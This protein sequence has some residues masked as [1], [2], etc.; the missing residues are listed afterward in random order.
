MSTV[1]DQPGGQ[2][3]YV[4]GILASLG[5]LSLG[6]AIGWSSPAQYYIM[7]KD[8]SGFPVTLDEFG[9]ICAA[10]WL[11]FG[12]V[13]IPSGILSE[14]WGRKTVM[15]LAVPLF[16]ISWAL[17]IFPFHSYIL[18][19]GRLVQGIAGGC[20]ILT[21][22]LYCT[23]IAQIDQKETLGAFFTIFLG[24]G[25]FYSYA[26]GAF[27]SYR[28]LNYGCALLPLLFLVTFAWMPESPVYYLLRGKQKQAEK[29]MKWLRNQNSPL[30][31]IELQKQITKVREQE[32]Q[33]WKTMCQKSNRRALFLCIGLMF[34]KNFCGGTAIITYCT[35][36]H[37]EAGTSYG[38]ESDMCTVI[39]GAV[40]VLF[41]IVSV[42]SLKCAGR[43]TM[44]MFT[45]CL[46][47]LCNCLMAIYL[48]LATAKVHYINTL[49]WLSFFGMTALICCYALGLG[50]LP[51]VIILDVFTVQFRTIGTGI[52]WTFFALFAF[53]NVKGLLTIADMWSLQTAFWVTTIFTIFTWIFIYFMLPETRDLTPEQ[54]QEK[55]LAKKCC[56][57]IA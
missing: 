8:A 13:I 2:N 31:L 40:L 35:A 41:T 30:E 12:V 56:T 21:V 32:P 10:L 45:T 54:I 43:R 33:P 55:L 28:Y 27:K 50:T 36:I 6:S 14:Y 42:Q 15:L 57:G 51:Y 16:M 3:Q 48:Y 29:S 9:W 19:L 11:G 52:V 38:F 39:G 17:I 37:E 24:L 34:C 4:A 5:A 53:V 47:A 20:Y 7:E 44:L 25:I 18:M 1:F 26:A 23:E 49:N 46:V 22:P